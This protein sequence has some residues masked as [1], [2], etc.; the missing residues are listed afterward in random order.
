VENLKYSLDGDNVV[1]R[2]AT[3]DELKSA[4]EAAIAKLNKDRAD[5]SMRSCW[6]CNPAHYHFLD[7]T[8]EAS[9]WRYRAHP[10]APA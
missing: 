6:V 2:P 7:D 5:M 4:R 1:S 10:P 8:N 3:P 9:A